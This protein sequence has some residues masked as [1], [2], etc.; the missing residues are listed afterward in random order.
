MRIVIT[1]PIRQSERDVKLRI[2]GIALEFA[3]NLAYR[4]CRCRSM[5]RILGLR[6]NCESN[7]ECC[8]STL[9]RIVRVQVIGQ[10][11]SNRSCK[12]DVASS[13]VRSDFAISS[14]LSAS[15]FLPIRANNKPS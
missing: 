8:N 14:C 10:G 12:R 2:V 11:L 5:F 6:R 13:S 7:N 4:C 1:I 3:L 9:S 15:A